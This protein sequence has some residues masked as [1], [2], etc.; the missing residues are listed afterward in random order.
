[1]MKFKLL[2]LCITLSVISSFAGSVHAQV[3]PSGNGACDQNFQGIL[4]AWEYYGFNDSITAGSSIYLMGN[5]PYG[6]FNNNWLLEWSVNWLVKSDFN[7]WRRILAGTSINN[8]IFT[9]SSHIIKDPS[10]RDPNY[11]IV[12]Y[13]FQFK[14]FNPTDGPNGSFFGDLKTHRECKS[15]LV[16]KCGDGVKDN[17][18]EECDGSD[19]VWLNQSCNA[20]CQI[21]TNPSE[22]VCPAIPWNQPT[23]PTWACND[24][25]NTIG[26]KYD[27]DCVCRGTPNTTPGEGVDLCNNIDGPQ[28]SIPF[29][30]VRNDNGSCTVPPVWPYCGDSVKQSNEQCDYN[31]PTTNNWG[32]LGCSQ[33]C[34][35]IMDPNTK[36][37]WQ[38]T[39][40]GW[41][42]QAKKWNWANYAA[43]GLY[44]V[45]NE[46][47]LNEGETPLNTTCGEGANTKPVWQCTANGWVKQAK[48]WNWANY[49]AN[50]AYQLNEEA[51]LNDGETPRAL[52]C[53]PVS[54]TQMRLSKTVDKTTVVSGDMVTYTIT[55]YNDGPGVIVASRIEDV[56]PLGMRFVSSDRWYHQIDP[57]RKYT[58]AS[59]EWL[60]ANPG[61]AQY[62]TARDDYGYW[63]QTFADGSVRWNTWPNGEA[64][65]V[66][67]DLYTWYWGDIEA[68]GSRTFTVT[69]Q[70]DGSQNG[71]CMINTATGGMDTPEYPRNITNDSASAQVCTAP[72]A[73]A[74]L[75]ITKWVLTPTFINKAGEI[76]SWTLNYGNSGAIAALRPAIVD[77]LPAGISYDDSLNPSS[78][79]S[80]ITVEPLA[81]GRQKITWKFAQDMAVGANGTITFKSRYNGGKADNVDLI[82]VVWIGTDTPETI[83][84]NN[85][86]SKPTKPYTAVAKWSLGNRVW[87]DAD[88][89]GIQ[90]TNETSL[91]G[92]RVEL[93]NC[94][95]VLLATTTTDANGMY[96]FSNLDAG[97]Y[98]VKFTLPNGY[99]WTQK[100][101]GTTIDSDVNPDGTT[102]C[103]TLAQ[104][105]NR[106]DID[107]GVFVPTPIIDLYIRKIADPKTFPNT[108]W[109]T[110]TWTI[111]YSNLG[112][113]TGTNVTIT[114]S[115]PESLAFVSSQP[116]VSFVW[117]APYLIP[118]VKYGCYPVPSDPTRTIC[119]DPGSA[120]NGVVWNVGT[121]RPGQTGQIIITTKY[122]WWVTDNVAILNTAIVVWDQTETIYTNNSTEDITKPYSVLADV[123][124]VKSV[125]KTWFVNSTGEIITWT[126]NY[127][128][129]GPS[130][131]TAVKVKDT[132]PASVAVY[133]TLNPWV[134]LLPNNMIE[135]SVGTLAAGQTWSISFQT[136]YLWWVANNSPIINNVAISTTTPETNYANNTWSAV[137]TPY[138]N[139]PI[140]GSLGD[141]VWIDADKDGIQDVGELSL[142][143]VKVEL[144][145]CSGALLATTVTNGSWEYLFNNLTAGN[146]KVK[147]TLPSGYSW[148]QKGIGTT[149]DSDVNP[150]GS[151]DCLTLAQGENRRDVDVGVVVNTTTVGTASLGNYVWI[152]A[153]KDGIQDANEV[154]LSDVKVD[155]YKITTC[156]SDL[157]TP[158]ATTTTNASGAY[159]FTGL[160]AGN[161]KVKFTLPNGYE[162][163]LPNQGTDRAVDS[164]AGLGG[165]TNC[166]TLAEGENNMT[167]D[168]GVYIEQPVS[169][170]WLILNTSV[171]NAGGS[172]GYSCTHKN[173]TS[174]VVTVTLSGSTTWV[175]SSTWFTG[176]LTI[177]QA[178]VYNVQC[179]LD[180]G[181][182]YKVVVHS[183]TSAAVTCAYKKQTTTNV[184][185]AVK[186]A[187]DPIIVS[188]VNL[189][190]LI[191][192]PT[193]YPYCTSTQLADTTYQ[194]VDAPAGSQILTRVDNMCTAQLTVNSTST[195]TSSGPGGT[196]IT[197]CGD[198]KVNNGEQCDGNNKTWFICTNQCI[199]VPVWTTTPSSRNPAKPKPRD[200]SL[201]SCE[202]I[203]PPSVNKWEYLP[204][205]WEL[206]S[207]SDVNFVSNCSDA[208]AG[209]TNVVKWWSDRS[210]DPLCHFTMY[211]DDT[212]KTPAASFSKYCYQDSDLQSYTLFQDFF[213]TRAESLKWYNRSK[214][215]GWS[216]FFGPSSWADVPNLYGEYKLSMDSSTFYV[217]EQ[218]GSV[219]KQSTQRHEATN[220]AWYTPECSFN[221]TVTTPYFVQQGKSLGTVQIS[222]WVLN[223]FFSFNTR[224]SIIDNIVQI[225]NYQRTNNLAYLGQQFAEKYTKLAKD[226]DI[227]F[228]KV[229]G[230]EIY[231]KVGNENLTIPG[232]DLPRG[233][234][235][236]N[237]GD[238]I[239]QGNLKGKVMMIANGG[240]IY[241]DWMSKDEVQQIEGI[242]IAD[243]VQSYNQVFN[244]DLS[245]WWANKWWIKIKGIIITKDATD[246]EQI[247][248]SRRSHL[249][250]WFKTDTNGSNYKK[251]AIL[252]GAALTIETDPSFWTSLPPGANELMSALE[253]YK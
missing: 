85:S 201:P 20:S 100:G 72:T 137:T 195:S 35:R 81:D 95:G 46:A 50:K 106:T 39:A 145:N 232:G 22:D 175:V 171:I 1:M 176:Q 172:V 153:D 177:S 117:P 224:G 178:G 74:D 29:G 209:K 59:P 47:S 120:P 96:L 92:V 139:N 236:S 131:A 109:Q 111:E 98:K 67:W 26:D 241:F 157:G 73:K 147:F 230:K 133:G 77:I 173:A 19:G 252:N 13:I 97:N 116:G 142:S 202:S 51:S 189:S 56:L 107:A 82:N 155:L 179:T 49:D 141:R 119:V 244:K 243:H 75:Y 206:E 65:H 158:V 165:I 250:N 215:D 148:T 30:M 44:Q 214:T 143:G 24:N 253:T 204:F 84:T 42:K 33:I 70:Y 17:W 194:C 163:T 132:M 246:I 23:K 240:T 161:Y 79:F 197:S 103:L 205:W 188:Q 11:L 235:I 170:E 128:N 229:A 90:D 169:C 191:Y 48:K 14:D 18:Y 122:L 60:K 86:D 88:K 138:S 162:F 167:I 41:V 233:T 130:A 16:T 78:V 108:T 200:I 251:D 223:N 237:G 217:C 21:T 210:N 57:V 99:S 247:Y 190:G 196:P 181:I 8:A 221:F 186:T 182:T 151:T 184:T 219:W 238:I 10:R 164:D 187:L 216:A 45:G 231:I 7:S 27:S 114:D 239:I 159:L 31:D 234:I 126:L 220:A 3:Y 105:E 127:K 166:I 87:I 40:N 208:I 43:N 245:K 101:G 25:N 54:Y 68:G 62:H 115:L 146:Y 222:Q 113:N 9:Q 226:Y 5:M 123:T 140:L 154:S 198:G 91:S 66:V 76:I 193:P 242:Y 110:I 160:A 212:T 63:R 174:A 129:N 134:T 168:A 34:E 36:P 144:Y 64:S 207:D 93:Y 12:N 32:T 83:Y 55:M 249:D 149:T 183:A 28:A 118:W 192:M 185:C 124:I 6:E 61:A 180:N 211:V 94:S 248:G 150:D 58:E 4:R 218:V 104:G 38:C 37:V 135:W 225:S 53:G 102:D 227:N 80:S 136:K 156:G 203:D 199:Y 52:T 228:K 15:Y 213:S 152:D 69:A 112:P 89:D 2:A 71:N 125:D 121:L